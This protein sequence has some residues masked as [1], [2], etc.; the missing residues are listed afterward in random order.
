MSEKE[1]EE[2]ILIQQGLQ[3]LCLQE[4]ET[5]LKIYKIDE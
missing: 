2:N 1:M 3:Y 4:S 5:K